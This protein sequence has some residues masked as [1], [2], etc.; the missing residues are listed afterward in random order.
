MSI[1]VFP[2]APVVNMASFLALIQLVHARGYVNIFLVDRLHLGRQTVK[3][4][5][6]TS[7]RKSKA[8]IFSKLPVA[9]GFLSVINL[10]FCTRRL[11]NVR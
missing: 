6:T 7:G 2:F 3:D 10:Q 8:F 11:M 9:E 5:S 4:S 1:N